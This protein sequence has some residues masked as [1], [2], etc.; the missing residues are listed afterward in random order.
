MSAVK[1]TTTSSAAAKADA[2]KRKR[3]GRP[4]K[5][6]SKDAIP[7]HGIVSEPSHI[8]EDE[9]METTMELQY[10]NPEMFKKIFTEF[11]NLSVENVRMQFHENGVSIIT[12]DHLQKSEFLAEILGDRLNKYYCENTLELGVSVHHLL[13]IMQT[14]KKDHSKITFLST[15][16]TQ[17][18]KLRVILHNATMNEDSGYNVD[19]TT[20][21]PYDGTIREDLL[22][23]PEYP[24]SFELDAKYF[25]N[26][27]ADW[28]R[29]GEVIKIEKESDGPLIINHVFDD[30]KGDHE[31][32]FKD[33]KKISLVANIPEGEMFAVSV[34]LH[35]LKPISTSTVADKIKVSAHENYKLI[36]TSLLDQEIDEDTNK[37][38]EGTEACV[39]KILTDI[40]D[41]EVAEED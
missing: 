32:I 5:K 4:K 15:R 18:S 13:Q 9:R 10:S 22:L 31:T 26:K 33:P 2:L 7:K 23:E 12:K 21:E 14:L 8:A 3:P 28:A 16:Q 39:I 1:K 30:K 20:I 36:F 41:F 25:K 35:N 17:R 24:L 19:V 6:I 27:V 29:L 40:V 11:K 38:I 37:P 34:L